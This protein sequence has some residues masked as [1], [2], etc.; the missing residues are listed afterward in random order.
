MP[1][2]KAKAKCPHCGT[3]VVL[4]TCLFERKSLFGT[5]TCGSKMYDRVEDGLL[6]VRCKTSF[7]T[8]KCS[9]CKND[10]PAADF[11]TKGPFGMEF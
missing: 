3:E 1:N 4:G 11:V 10:I 7:E 9:N 2:H 8:V 5:K 6:C